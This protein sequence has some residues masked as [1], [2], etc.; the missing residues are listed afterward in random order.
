MSAPALAEQQL[1]KEL[2]GTGGGSSSASLPV[3]DLSGMVRKKKKP[4]PPETE[5]N[6]PSGTNG[7][8][9]ADEENPDALPEKKLKTDNLVA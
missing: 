8:R 1:A 3:N 7:K 6:E 5:S 2:N 9:K 4:I